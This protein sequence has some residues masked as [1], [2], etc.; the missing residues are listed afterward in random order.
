[1]EEIG[2]YFK[3]MF[4]YIEQLFPISDLDKKGC[5]DHMSLKEY[6]KDEYLSVAGRVPQYHHF[7]VNGHARNFHYDQNG[8][9]VTVDLNEGPR[10]FTS[11][12]HFINKTVSNENLQCITDCKV[13]RLHRDDLE[14][15][16]KYHPSMVEYSALVL[17]E[18]W[19]K[20]KQRMIDRTTLSA[21]ERYL[22][23]LEEQPRLIQVYPLTHIASYLGIRPGSLSRIRKDL[24][25][26]RAH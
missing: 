9:E 16:S 5:A 10:F 2:A 25:I 13:L 17:Q 19:A 3:V 12:S 4:D 23:L 1:M 20:E 6:S 14:S 8:E 7:L 26:T 24:T 11:Y 18:S 22:K 15:M 21:E